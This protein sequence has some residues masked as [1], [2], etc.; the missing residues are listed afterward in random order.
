MGFETEK[1]LLITEVK[2]FSVAESAGLQRGDIIIE[3]NREEV[4]AL[5]DLD[6]ILKASDPGDPLLMMIRREYRS[7]PSQDFFVTVRIPE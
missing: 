5:D 2:E 3:I 4:D 1:G 7:R 6:K